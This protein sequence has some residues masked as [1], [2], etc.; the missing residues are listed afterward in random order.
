MTTAE[1]EQMLD[2]VLGHL[3]DGSPSVGHHNAAIVLL[4]AE[5]REQEAWALDRGDY[6][7]IDV[8][9]ITGRLCV[10]CKPF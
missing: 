8:S 6:V 7:V 2:E 10:Y 1:K 9:P 3:R 5:G 4:K